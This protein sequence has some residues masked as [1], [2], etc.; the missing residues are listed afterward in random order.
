VKFKCLLENLLSTKIKRLQTDGGGEFTSL[1]FEKYLSDNGIFHQKSCPHTSQQNGIAERKHRHIVETGLTLL[2]QSHLP[3]RYWVEAFQTGVYLINRLPSSTIKFSTPYF[4]LFKIE[5]DYASLKVFGCACYP[6]LR[7]YTKHKLEFRSKQCIFLGYSSNHKGYRCLD[8]NTNRI[9]ISRNVV[10][11]E[12]LFPAQDRF[13]TS[14]S[15]RN[16]SPASGIVL[17][18]SQ[19]YSTSSDLISTAVSPAELTSS[20]PPVE[21]TSST[22]LVEPVGS[23]P[24]VEPTSSAPLVEHIGSAP[25][26]EPTCSAPTS[27]LV[28]S[29]HVVSAPTSPNIVTR[30]MT[31][32]LEPKEYPGFHL[33]QSIKS[34]KHPLKAMAAATLPREPTSYSQAVKNPDWLAAMESEFQA[35]LDNATWTLCSRPR[36]R[37]V[38]H[39]KWVY[40]LKQKPNGTIDRYKAR[41]V[42]K[43]FE[44]RDGI[45]YSETFSPVIKPATMR[46]LLA[47][48]VNFQWP[49]KQLDVSNAFLHGNLL[50]EV[51]MEQPQGFVDKRYPDFV[52]KLNKA[53]YGLKQ[54]PRA[55]FHRLTQ[56]L[57]NLGFIGSL[58]DTSLFVL[59]T[60]S[61]HIFVLIYVDDIIITGTD[62]PK[63]NA[64]ISDLQAEFKMKDLGALSYFLGIHVSRNNQGLYLNQAKYVLDLLHRVDMI[65]AKP[66]AAPCTSGKKLTKFDGD[67]L[68][69]PSLYRHIVGAL[70]YCTLTRPDIAYSVNQLCQFLHCPTTTHFQ[71]AKRVLKYLKGTP[72]H[73]L[74]FTPGPIQLNAY[75]DSDWAGDPIDRRSTSGYGVFLGHC[76]LS[77]Q[78]KKQPVVSRS[79][80]EAEYRAMAIATAELYWLRMLFRE[81]NI[82]LNNPPTLWCD[83]IGALALASNPIY[84]A[85]TKHIEVD[86]HFIR[87]KILHKDMLASYISTEDQSADIFTKGLTSQRFLFLRDKLMVTTP[88]MCLKGAVNVSTA[89]LSLSHPLISNIETHQ[90]KD[91]QP[92]LISTSAQNLRYISRPI[93]QIISNG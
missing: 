53:L 61:V 50:E 82:S 2:A 27:P 39:N 71:A 63:I 37:N 31:G 83:N 68:P 62:L 67:P 20:A 33:Y 10:F 22:L 21:P 78:A 52:C 40:K 57:H 35:L 73:G 47:L 3:S 42:A 45:D 9:Y 75:C 41:L 69:D 54:A 72:D 70:Q 91:K 64:I 76:L 77:W 1:A 26:A 86:Y 38:I 51:Y 44:Q 4:K 5:P 29:L 16:Q 60:S 8:P 34:T 25:S 49:I 12:N 19:F 59:H 46:L 7:P 14:Q 58:V 93:Q 88:P 79:S 92:N 30:S 36:G 84:H 48:A 28:D 90:D 43:G 18:P 13:Q 15:A 11:D 23:A 55:W 80:T 85:R 17:I 87:E 81:L 6:L 89:M 74:L 66:Y 32:H 65:G 24:S 56:A